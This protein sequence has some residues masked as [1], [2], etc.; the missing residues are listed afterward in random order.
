MYFGSPAEMIRM[1]PVC[2]YS[3]RERRWR[4]TQRRKA[5]SPDFPQGLALPHSSPSCC[6]GCWEF[7]LRGCSSWGQ[8]GTWW[9]TAAL[10]AEL[11]KENKLFRATLR[12]GARDSVTLSLCS[13]VC[14]SL[15]CPPDTPPPPSK[16]SKTE[17]KFLCIPLPCLWKPEHKP[18]IWSVT[19]LWE[20]M[21]CLCGI[22]PWQLTLLCPVL[23]LVS[24][25]IGIGLCISS[26]SLHLAPAVSPPLLQENVKCSS[27]AY[28][29]PY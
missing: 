29:R 5:F 10:E 13:W 1:V 14:F 23:S 6:L 7:T 8:R 26:P 4:V 16:S 25:F 3:R 9:V 20:M 21:Y 11:Y 28:L 27:Q 2:C 17:D 22:W 18:P 24:Q 19:C 12:C 15:W